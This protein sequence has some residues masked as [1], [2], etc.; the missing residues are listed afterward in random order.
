MNCILAV[1]NKRIK[2]HELRHGTKREALGSLVTVNPHVG[3]CDLITGY[4][5]ADWL[6]E[7]IGLPELSLEPA[8]YG[9]RVCGVVCNNHVDVE[10]TSGV[11]CGV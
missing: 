6:A 2:V 4:L 10:W 9:R 8:P 11:W 1:D 5:V 7:A 3:L